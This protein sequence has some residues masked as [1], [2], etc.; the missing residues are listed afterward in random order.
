MTTIIHIAALAAICFYAAARLRRELQML[1]Q[2]SYRPDRYWRWLRGQAGVPSVDVV[3]DILMFTMLGGFFRSSVAI[4]AIVAIALASLYKGVRAMLRR[5]KKPL[6]FTARAWRIYLVA[7][8]LTL[9]A[10]AGVWLWGGVWWAA[11]VALVTGV[12]G[13]PYVAIAA[14]WMLSPVE[15][16][17]NRRY[18]DDARRILRSL[19]RLVVIGITGSYGKTSTKHYLHRILSERFS[20]VMTPGSF[21]TTLGVVR[22]IREHLKPYTEVFIVEMG[23]KQP[24]DIAEICELV[25][26][27]IGII[28]AVGEQH[29]ESFKTIEN[30]QRTK[31]EL[32]DA[33]PPDGVAILNDDFEYIASRPVDNVAR[34]MRYTS[35]DVSPPPFETRLVGRYNLSNI[36]AAWL[37][38]RTL[39]MTDAEMRHAIADIRSVEHRLEVRRTPG[40]V[41]IIDDAFNSNPHGAAMALEVLAGFGNNTPQSKP[42]AT[43]EGGP[44]R[45]DGSPNASGRRII[46][47]PGMIELGPKQHELN[48]TFGRQIAAAADIAVIVG[49]YNR[50]AIL[51]GLDDEGFP[52]EN[53]YAA[54]DFADASQHVSKLTHTGDT[55]LYENDLPDTFR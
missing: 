54:N 10:T 44:G 27:S 4:Y 12:A 46:V 18:L 34:V 1:Q 55:I 43:H 49:Q 36:Y 39:G 32:I 50:Q 45:P 19:P 53:I 28:T 3:T 13:A 35:R 51:A 48:R 37:A 16:A 24:G 30:V 8:G 5:S 7:L 29:L 22:T 31:F 6:V 38:G 25:H 21:N 41:T 47:T 33:L 14:V 52:N 15:R 11:A 17:I 2:N 26:P 23:A 40:G 9:A 20:V 42:Q